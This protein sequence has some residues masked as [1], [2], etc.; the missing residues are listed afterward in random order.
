MNTIKG[1]DSMSRHDIRCESWPSCHQNSNRLGFTLIELLL[2]L[3]L[4]GVGLMG[5]IPNLIQTAVSP[6][7]IETFL[8][9]Q[10]KTAYQVAQSESRPVV[11]TGF[12]GSG[13]MINAQDKRVSFP[14]GKVVLST[15]VNGERSRGLEYYIRVYPHGLCDDF[16][17][18]FEDDIKVQSIPILMS[19]VVQSK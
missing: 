9:E 4:I 6:N 7:P 14:D 18:E 16:E 8:N 19:A 13:N 3:L 1:Q 2:V 17:I 10:I 5:V 15:K 11:I 12:S